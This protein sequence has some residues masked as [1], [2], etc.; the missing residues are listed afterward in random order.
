MTFSLRLRTLR[1]PLRDPFVIARSSHG[2][3][4][5]VTTVI[6]T[7]RDDAD[8]DDGPIGIGE[9]YPD[10]YYGDTPETMAAVAPLLLSSLDPIAGDLRGS[11]DDVRATLE[12]AEGLM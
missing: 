7:L 12:D 2:E 11:L 8:G 4:Q 1:L 3:G 6:A 5:T 9:G 10:A